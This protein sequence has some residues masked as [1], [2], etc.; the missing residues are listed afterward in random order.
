MGSR[1]GARTRTE[2]KSVIYEE[3][4]TL[5][6]FKVLALC[7]RQ[8][9]ARIPQREGGKLQRVLSPSA[10]TGSN[11]WRSMMTR[12]QQRGLRIKSGLSPVGLASWSC[13]TSLFSASQGVAQVLR[14][15]ECLLMAT[16]RSAQAHPAP[17]GGVA[18]WPELTR[19]TG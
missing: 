19:L 6:K 8:L 2:Y 4:G 5:C 14:R 17:G 11:V 15:P 12:S 7:L 18:G 16:G 10:L 9:N 1:Q 3:K 13:G